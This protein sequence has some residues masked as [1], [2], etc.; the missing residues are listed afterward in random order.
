MCRAPTKRATAVAMMPIGAGSGDEHVLAD[1]A[2][3]E[4]GVGRV[5]ERIENR[6]DVVGNGLRELEGIHRR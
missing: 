6:G 1:D 3:G 5:A 2:E 4:G